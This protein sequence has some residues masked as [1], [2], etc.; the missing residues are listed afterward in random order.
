MIFTHKVKFAAIAGFVSFALAIALSACS[1]AEGDVVLPNIIPLV[2]A[3]TVTYDANAGSDSVTGTVAQQKVNED[4]FVTV[5]ENAYVREGWYFDGWNTAADGSGTKYAAGEVI[6]PSGSITLYAQWKQKI[7][8]G[9]VV[10]FKTKGDDSWMTFS[11]TQVTKGDAVATPSVNPTTTGGEFAG[12]FTSADEGKTLEAT[13][14]DFSTAINEDLTLYANFYY[15]IVFVPNANDGSVSG[16]M[17]EMKVLSGMRYSLTKNA[18]VREGYLFAGWNEDTDGSAGSYADGQTILVVDANY[19]LYAQWIPIQSGSH[20]VQFDLNGGSGSISIQQIEDG[21]TATRP[22]TDPTKDGAE[23][24]DWFTSTDGGATLSDTPFDFSTLIT[25]DITLYAKWTVKT[26]KVIFMNDSTMLEEQN[27]AYGD[28]VKPLSN[29]PTKY[30]YTL[31]G[32]N[33]KQDGT[34]VIFNL[35]TS[36]TTELT[37]YAQWRINTYKVTFI[38][39][40]ISYSV[41]V[42]HGKTIEKPSD[43]TKDGNVFGGWFTSTDGGA[44]LSDTAFDFSSPIT[45][46]LALYAKWTLETYFVTFNANGGEGTMGKQ[47][48]TY[49]VEQTLSENTFSRGNDY[50]FNGWNTAADGSGTTYSNGQKLTLTASLTLYAQWKVRPANMKTVTFNS[51]GGSA[52]DVAMVEENKPVTKPAN[53]TKDGYD[54]TGWFTSTDGGATLSDT[55]FN[56]ETAITTDLTL[57]AGWKIKTY[58][59]TFVTGEG[60]TTVSPQSLEY[61][62]TAQRPD[63]PAKT[64][65]TFE[66]WF[67]STDEGATLSDMEFD[68]A[69]KITASVKL[70]AKWKIETYKVTFMDGSGILNTVNADY[71]T[72]VAEPTKPEKAKAT[73]ENW[74]ADSAFAKLFD[75]T[76]PIVGE[77]KVYARWQYTVTYEVNGGSYIAAVIVKDGEELNRPTN[78]TKE[79]LTF[80]GWYSDAEFTVAF[81]FTKAVT[82]DVTAYAQWLAAVT[83]DAKNGSTVTTRKVTEGSKVAKPTDP[84]MTG[85]EF[86]GWFTSTDDGTTLSDTPFDF[87]TVITKNLAL[88]AGWKQQFFNITYYEA[89]GS[90]FSGTHQEGYP[91]R[92]GYGLDTELDSPTSANSEFGFGGWFRGERNPDD[93]TV[94]LKGSRLT[95]LGATDYTADIELY[96]KWLRSTFYVSQT[97]NNSTGTG[98]ADAPLA[99]IEKAISTITAMSNK[100]AYTIVVDGELKGTNV[101]SSG[102][103]AETSAE[104]LLIRGKTGSTTDIL[105]GNAGGTVLTIGSRVPITMEK[106]KITNGSNSTG[107]GGVSVSDIKSNVTLGTDL[108]I[109]ENYGRDGGGLGLSGAVTIDGAEI[110]NNTSYQYGGVYISNAIGATLT[111]NSGKISGNKSTATY[112]YDQT[113]GGGVIIAA[114]RIFVMNGGEISDNDIT[115]STS[116]AYGGGVCVN[117][118]AKFVMNGGTIKGNKA[119][120]N[121]GTAVYVLNGTES[122]FT[123]SGSASIPAGEDGKHTVFLY[124][125]KTITI[126]GA[127]TGTA[128]VA[129]I[130]PDPFEAGKQVLSSGKDES[131]ADIPITADIAAKFAVAKESDVFDRWYVD[132]EG[133]L[134]LPVYKITYKDK[135]GEAFTGTLP[136]GAAVTH[137]YGYA[138]TLPEPKKEG[139]MFQGW[140]KKA[141]CSDPAVTEVAVHEYTEDFTLYARWTK[142]VVLFTVNNEDVAIT[143]DDSAADGTVTLTAADGFSDYAWKID[144]PL[145][146][147]VADGKK[148]TFDKAKLV[149]GISYVISVTAKNSNGI[150]L[151]STVTVKMQEAE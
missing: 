13:P 58:T 145:D 84:Q 100:V 47:T 146:G 39:T 52:V 130:L 112:R 77:T 12:W 57:Y 61:N 62:G 48:F 63:A 16:T 81:D 73:F 37:L 49:G 106:L 5:A 128:P 138:T 94:T 76:K 144:M 40:P 56:F 74:Y 6:E 24:A 131:G 139:F 96:A 14:F 78:P 29:V 109:T 85:C 82:A 104:S 36:V 33:T 148:F 90:A 125:E 135:D 53:P 113:Y 102:T 75:F 1:G 59:V 38:N 117:N 64:G 110:I 141:D 45:S 93:G 118:G 136:E 114:G 28:K 143:K 142:A 79:G 101:I 19:V 67:V 108:V 133:K 70:Y 46:P 103:L 25:S 31:I 88:Y 124:G 72:T 137:T 27:I 151:R 26:Y 30:G 95:K 44:T 122:T 105:N 107:A 55:P 71:G 11:I 42:E 123:M 34:G 43:P 17:E 98:E 54:F 32:W 9:C 21:K 15:K 89:D 97:G 10:T 18:F 83:F 92:H 65:Y 127:L 22:A 129:T 87:D 140:H 23:F 134:A 60:A 50:I 69:T 147:S 111:M 86:L 8:N 126:G 68:F 2:T 115:S 91:T 80:N 7:E 119:K 150:I 51:M 121:Q 4:G 149:K 132:G 99:T 116:N 120:E 35:N 3:K 66:G 41:T 20:A